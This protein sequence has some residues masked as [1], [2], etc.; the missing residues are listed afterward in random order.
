MLSIITG[1]T[2]PK[3]NVHVEV[4]APIA[5]SDLEILRGLDRN[6]AT[7]A[8]AHIIDKRIY[9]NYKLWN[10]NF[11]AYDML[12][13]TFEFTDQYSPEEYRHFA[14]RMH[15]QLRN[16]PD[17]KLELMNIFLK[18]YS[19]PVLNCLPADPRFSYRPAGK[20]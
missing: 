7:L 6:E 8:I 1:I 14:A 5:Q 20:E 3:G 18:L 4:C 9:D 10:T 13:N 19:N 11:I 2:Q 16:W 15:E 17:K 12:Y